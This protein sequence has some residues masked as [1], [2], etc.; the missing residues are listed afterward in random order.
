MKRKFKFKILTLISAFLCALTLIL[1]C[2]F[3]DAMTAICVGFG[4]LIFTAD[5]L[6]FGVLYT[7][8]DEVDDET[9]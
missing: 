8:T 5:A 1:G 9:R 3:G 2:I 6:I 4:I 7:L